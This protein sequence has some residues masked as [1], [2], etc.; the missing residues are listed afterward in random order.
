MLLG[1]GTDI[2][3]NSRFFCKSDA[4]LRK[5]F[6][7]SEV[8]KINECATLTK[9]AETA[10]SLFALKEAVSKA[11]GFSLFDVGIKNITVKNDERGKPVV[12]LAEPVLARVMRFYNISD[13]NLFS[14]ISH[15]EDYS[16]AFVVFEGRV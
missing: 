8:K 5:L 15:E 16:V 9:K 13:V 4:F 11:L 14:S 2:V 7:D 1:C 12:S 10:G 3:L 6:I